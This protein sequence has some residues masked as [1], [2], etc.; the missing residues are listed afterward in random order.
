MIKRQPIVN[1]VFDL[2]G[3][4]TDPRDIHNSKQ[5]NLFP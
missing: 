4:L 1:I 2:D 3:T 5:L